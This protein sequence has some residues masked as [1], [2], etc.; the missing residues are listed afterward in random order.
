MPAHYKPALSP[1]LL[2]PTH[3]LFPHS[4]VLPSYDDKSQLL[5]PAFLAGFLLITF[6]I[7]FFNASLSESSL[8]WF[9]TN[10]GVFVSMS[11]YFMH[12][13]NRSIMYL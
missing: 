6:N 10:S 9:H 7:Y 8:F 4:V 13:S 12:P 1:S 11:F 2:S 3:H 5:E